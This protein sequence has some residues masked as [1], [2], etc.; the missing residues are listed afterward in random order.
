MEEIRDCRYCTNFDG[1]TCS[2][3]GGDNTDA[4]DC[5]DYDLYSSTEY[6]EDVQ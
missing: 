2:V 3:P 1:D 4:E 6:I 5:S